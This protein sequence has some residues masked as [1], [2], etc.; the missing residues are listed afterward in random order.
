MEATML[1]LLWV[2][3]LIFTIAA[4][5]LPEQFTISIICFILWNSLAILCTNTLFIG[6]GSQNAIP[7]S[8]ELGDNNDHMLIWIFHMLGI[9]MFIYGFGNLMSASKKSM[10]QVDNAPHGFVKGWYK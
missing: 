4:L 1:F 8:L 10:D 5:L 6:F 3:S 2:T 9:F 7:Y